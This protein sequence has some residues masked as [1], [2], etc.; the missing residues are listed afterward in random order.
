MTVTIAAHEID[1]HNAATPEL[2]ATRKKFKDWD[3]FTLHGVDADGSKF[4]V[5]FH[6][7]SGAAFEMAT[8]FADHP[9][10]PQSTMGRPELSSTISLH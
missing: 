2:K 7:D 8:E 1:S 9:D 4:K 6:P 5:E 10:N 3:C